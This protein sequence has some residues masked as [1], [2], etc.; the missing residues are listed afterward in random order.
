MLFREL[1]KTRGLAGYFFNFL[2]FKDSFSDKEL[3]TEV[4]GFL[5]KGLRSYKECIKEENY[6]S[7]DSFSIALK[8]IHFQKLL[9]QEIHFQNCHFKKYIFKITI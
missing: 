5:L 4:K 2:I 3:Q 9:P 6:S 1:Y 8:K 7:L